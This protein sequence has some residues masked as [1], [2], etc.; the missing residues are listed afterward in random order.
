MTTTEIEL[1]EKILDC[2]GKSNY[3]LGYIDFDSA[4]CSPAQKELGIPCLTRCVTSQP[5]SS[6]V[7]ST[8]ITVNSL[9]LGMSVF[10]DLNHITLN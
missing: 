10:S 9:K 7:K 3:Y 8:N 4:E 6:T 2:D 1:A 5:G